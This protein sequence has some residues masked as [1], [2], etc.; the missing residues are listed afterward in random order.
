MRILLKFTAPIWWLVGLISGVAFTAITFA[1]WR[2]F[3]NALIV[4]CSAT[5]L[6]RLMRRCGWGGLTIGRTIMLWENHRVV[7]A[8]E[9]QH[10]RQG[11]AYGIAF[12]LVYCWELINRGYEANRF[13]IEAREVGEIER[14]LIDG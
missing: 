3:Q 12:P 7:M 14:K 6:G 4:D 11:D 2:W 1:R 8:H 5:W 10:V 13:E 9:F